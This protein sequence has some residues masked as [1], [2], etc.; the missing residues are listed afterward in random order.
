MYFQGTRGKVKIDLILCSIY[1][2]GRFPVSQKIPLLGPP[3]DIN[4]EY[5]SAYKISTYLEN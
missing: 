3:L 5:L 1:H 2:T 4:N